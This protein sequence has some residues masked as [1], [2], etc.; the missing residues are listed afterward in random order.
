M[1][2]KLIAFM[3]PVIFGVAACDSPREE[4]REETRDDRDVNVRVEDRRSAPAERDTV[5]IGV[6]N[7]EEERKGVEIKVEEG[8]DFE[9][10]RKGN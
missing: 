2:T 5:F 9:I 6:E 10:K 4:A 1:K 3:L 7:K 8:G